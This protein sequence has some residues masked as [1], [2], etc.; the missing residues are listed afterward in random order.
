MYKPED[1]E[2]WPGFGDTLENKPYIQKKQLENWHL[3]GK[4]WED[5]AP[6]VARYMAMVTQTDAS[7]GRILDLLEEKGQ[8]D[9]TLII[10]TADHGDTSGDHGM[11]D[12]HYILYDGVTHIPFIVRW[13][14]FGH[15]DVQKFAC[16]CLDLG[17]TI[18][19]VCG[20]H[21]DFPRHGR[22]V[23]AYIDGSET[24]DYAVFTSN[25]QQFGLFT[26]RGIRTEKYK[27]I[28]N[29]TDIDEFYD[30]EK[31]PGEKV[32]LAGDPAYAD[33]IR[34]LGETMYRELQRRGDP[35]AN[36]WV[37]WQVGC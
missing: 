18:E 7:I 29:L 13:P 14:Q 4:T 16:Q 28:W 27:Y 36:G 6:T 22:S 34:Q 20:V 23:R 3:V 24:P 35:F 15:A 30:L 11:M 19:D 17:P 8:L 25:G 5:F 2:P 10:L 21:T 1:M 26:Q 33:I 9:N 12:K 31:D 32:N 37:G